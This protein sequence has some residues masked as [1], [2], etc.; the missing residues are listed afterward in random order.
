MPAPFLLIA[1]ALYHNDEIGNVRGA[2]LNGGRKK[3]VPVLFNR[4]P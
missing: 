1:P 3:T 2:T 4:L